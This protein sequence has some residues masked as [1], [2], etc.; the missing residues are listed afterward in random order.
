[1]YRITEY[2]NRY[3]VTRTRDGKRVCKCSDYGHAKHLCDM[4]NHA[5]ETI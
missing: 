1:M 4:M 3:Y 2:R 5:M